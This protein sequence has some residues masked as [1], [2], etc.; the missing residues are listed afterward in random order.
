MTYLVCYTLSVALDIHSCAYPDLA[1]L[2]QAALAVWHLSILSDGIAFLGT[3]WCDDCGIVSLQAE[4]VFH[5][6]K[7]WG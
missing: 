6:G 1:F 5:C 4:K 7:C 2:S 3:T